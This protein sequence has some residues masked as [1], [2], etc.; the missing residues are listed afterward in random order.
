M[1]VVR[2]DIPSLIGVDF[3]K[4]FDIGEMQEAVTQGISHTAL[5]KPKLSIILVKFVP[6]LKQLV[7][8]QALIDKK[9]IIIQ[10]LQREIKK[11]D[12]LFKKVVKIYNVKN[13]QIVAIIGT[14]PGNQP[15]YPSALVQTS[16]LIAAVTSA[17]ELLVVLEDKL[18]AEV[19]EMSERTAALKQE[20]EQLG[21]EIFTA[22]TQ[23]EPTQYNTDENNFIYN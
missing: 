11:T 20:T 10:E 16:S 23:Y 14:T 6:K 2:A 7:I 5:S 18:D 13:Q 15:P 4:I 9:I 3:S 12:K 17:Q 21:Q 22:L 8:K 19:E 1:I